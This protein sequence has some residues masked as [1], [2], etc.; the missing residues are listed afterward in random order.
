MNEIDGAALL[1]I[2]LGLCIGVI[3]LM[4]GIATGALLM[5]ATFV[6]TLGAM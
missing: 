6:A 2:L 3:V 1:V 4:L 5:V